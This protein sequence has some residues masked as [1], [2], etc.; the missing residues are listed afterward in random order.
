MLQI[1]DR[2]SDNIFTAVEDDFSELCLLRSGLVALLGR[3]ES[4]NNN[5]RSAI[6]D[7]ATFVPGGPLTVTATFDAV[8][9]RAAFSPAQL[10]LSKRL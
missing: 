8:T 9:A 10:G 5:D 1:F 3:M 4:L 6:V 2:T 7:S